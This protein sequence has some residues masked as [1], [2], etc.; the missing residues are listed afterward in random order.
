[1]YANKCTRNLIDLTRKENRKLVFSGYNKTSWL[2]LKDI[3]RD[4][5]LRVI[6]K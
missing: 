6:N 4:H 1:M 3:V 2:E 5:R